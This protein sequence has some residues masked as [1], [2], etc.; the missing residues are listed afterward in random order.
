MSKELDNKESTLL[1]DYIFDDK[2]PLLKTKM[3]MFK[4]LFKPSSEMPSELKK[5]VR[6]PESLFKT[7]RIVSPL[8]FHLPYV[9]NP[10]SIS[11]III[12]V[13][14]FL[15]LL[16][17]LL[18]PFRERPSSSSSSIIV[19]TSGVSTSALLLGRK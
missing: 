10:S 19:D 4:D 13:S 16:P 5:H 12:Y 11:Y 18:P 6:Y 7:S 1:L 15:H 2:D 14:Y 17:N 3:A 9:G 8:Y